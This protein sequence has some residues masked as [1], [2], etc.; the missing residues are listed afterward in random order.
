M[1]DLIFKWIRDFLTVIF[2][3]LITLPLTVIYDIVTQLISMVADVVNSFVMTEQT[4]EEP[5]Q[6]TEYPD[7]VKIKGFKGMEDE[8]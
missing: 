7:P 2:T 1:I 4:E 5:T 8:K 6:N 3:D